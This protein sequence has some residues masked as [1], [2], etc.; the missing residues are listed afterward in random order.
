M[1]VLVTSI[2]STPSI[3]V[4]KFIRA[5]KREIEIVG[6]DINF[7]C[8]IAGASLV[9]SFFKVPLNTDPAYLGEMLKIIKK[10]NIQIL[11]P[12]HDYEI[13][14][15][16]QETEKIQALGCTIITS[17]FQTIRSVND[18]YAFAQL[19]KKENILTPVTYSVGQWQS[20]TFNEAEIWIMKPLR[21][22]SSKGI[23]KGDTN[24]INFLLE[25]AGID[26]S[27]YM[28]QQYVPGEEYTVDVFVKN[29][30]SYCIVPR[31]R[32]E[33]REG[34]CYKCYTIPN[35]KFY[36]AV[37]HVIN[38]YDFYGPINIQFIESADHK[39]Y[40]IECNPRFGGS[41]VT[42]LYAGINLFQFILDDIENKQ[43][44]FINNYKSIYMTRYWE[45][46]IYEK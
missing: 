46:V 38:L 16:S 40:C 43:L 27:T 17:S 35:E 36:D 23:Y 34:I 6:T 26:D 1:R 18:K 9:D 13:E 4:V 11:V 30:K 37:N 45:E 14:V 25:K 44:T 21:G 22:V 29:K 41:S 3:G 5:T 2:G 32:E 19:L 28:I 39:L 12:I 31:V 10:E 7:N 15:L 24:E 20:M 42:T 33:I 8:R